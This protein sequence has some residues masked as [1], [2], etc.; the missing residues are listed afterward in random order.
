MPDLSGETEDLHKSPLILSITIDNGKNVC[1]LRQE[2]QFFV[3]KIVE[4]DTCKSA[5]FSLTIKDNLD[6]NEGGIISCW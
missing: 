6:Y 1:F 2:V 5:G 4:S 3:Q